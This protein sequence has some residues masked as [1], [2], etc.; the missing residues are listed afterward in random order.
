MAKQTLQQ[1]YNKLM[2]SLCLEHLTIG[3]MYSQ[4]TE[5]WGKEEMIK[6]V[7][8]QLSLYYQWGTSSGDMR[9]DDP[10]TWRKEVNKLKRFLQTA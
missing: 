4:G 6:E 3:T 5:G 2:N 8:Y 9:E 1:K 7:K 10:A